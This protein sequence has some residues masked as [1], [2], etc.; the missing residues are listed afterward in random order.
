MPR[1]VAY[2]RGRELES[3]WVRNLPRGPDGVNLGSPFRCL[4]AGELE[5]WRPSLV[6]SPTLVEEGLPLLISNLDLGLG[7]HSRYQFFRLFPSSHLPLST[8]VRMNAAFPFVSPAPNLP[9]APPVVSS[10]PGTMITTAS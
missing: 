1:D 8:A 6:F 9:T 2:D 4:R 5:G 7:D 3:V 10:T